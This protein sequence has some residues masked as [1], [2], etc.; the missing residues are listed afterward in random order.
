MS[1]DYADA[2]HGRRY[3][4]AQ[5]TEMLLRFERAQGRP[6]ENMAELEAWYPAQGF[7]RP[8][9]PSQEAWDRAKAEAAERG[10]HW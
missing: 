4:T 2:L 5:A 6:A 3:R 7:E 8:V 1:E 9:K 10:E